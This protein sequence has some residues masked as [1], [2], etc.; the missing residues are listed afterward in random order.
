[1]AKWNP[2]PGDRHGSPRQSYWSGYSDAFGG[3]DRY[4]SC[5]DLVA[6][7]AH[8][9]EGFDDALADLAKDEEHV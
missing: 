5:A 7:N 6:A 8:Y 2:R 9:N 3:Y 4:Q 1:M